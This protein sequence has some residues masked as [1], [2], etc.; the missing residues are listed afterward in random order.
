MLADTGAHAVVYQVLDDVLG[1][2]CVPAG[3]RAA[4]FGVV[5]DLRA[6]DGATEEARRAEQIAIEIHKFEWALRDGDAAAAE[7]ARNALKLLAAEWINTRICSR[8]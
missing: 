3:A 2:S 1:A 6:A 5:D 8:H 4:L 7:S